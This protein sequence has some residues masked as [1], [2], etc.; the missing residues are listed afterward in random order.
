[1]YVDKDSNRNLDF[2]AV[3]MT[4]STVNFNFLN[5]LAKYLD[6]GTLFLLCCF[7]PVSV[8][9]LKSSLLYLSVWPFVSPSSFFIFAIDSVFNSLLV[10]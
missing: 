4:R 5:L 6:C 3:M 9:F 10:I 1:M 8:A 2:T 7:Y